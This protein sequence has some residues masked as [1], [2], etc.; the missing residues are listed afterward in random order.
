MSQRATVTTLAIWT[1]VAGSNA[2]THAQSESEQSIQRRVRISE[3]QAD[4]ELRENA[5]TWHDL[6][7][8]ES[9]AITIRQHIRVTLG[10]EHVPPAGELNPIVR[11]ARSGDGYSV[12]NIGFEA[13]PGFW[14]TG[15]LYRPLDVE[16]PFAGV[17]CPHGH[18]GATGDDAEGR[19][20]RSMQIR[21][22][23]LAR[24]GAVVFAYDMAG[25]GESNQVA[26][27]HPDT[28]TLQALSSIRSVDFLLSRPDVDPDRLAVT[29]ASG[30]GSQSFLLT[31]LDPRIDV[32]VPVVMVSAH[33]FGG[34][35][36]ETGK[37]IHE[38]VRHRTNNVEIA[39]LAAPRPQMLISCGG[40]WTSRTP[41]VELPYIESVYRLYDAEDHIKNAHFAAE[42]HDYGPSK[43]H[44][45]YAFL[46]THLGLDIARITD[47]EGVV[48][49]GFVTLHTRPDL[50]VFTERKPRPE[51]ALDGIEDVMRAL[52]AQIALTAMP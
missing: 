18:F 46:G 12:E 47:E 37:L 29:G 22:A 41:S 43:R 36:C 19:F 9:R 6:A 34:C 8:W 2:M 40:D 16:P 52:R 51:H 39:A 23:S 31:A 1:I 30:G 42:G 28:L 13:I 14:V 33:F 35:R 11:D 45:M 50:C 26:H 44:A 3:V 4:A 10:L 21:C 27:R 17:L 24:M 32:S 7:T 5:A 15:N 48:D 49:E 38:S 20:R 25:W